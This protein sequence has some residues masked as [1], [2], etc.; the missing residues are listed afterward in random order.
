[1]FNN[2]HKVVQLLETNLKPKKATQMSEYLLQIHPIVII[3]MAFNF[4]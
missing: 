3:K 1:M 4:L 2:P